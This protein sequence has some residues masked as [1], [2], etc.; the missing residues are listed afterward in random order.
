VVENYSPTNC[1]ALIKLLAENGT[2]QV[3]T[4]IWERG[5]WL[6]DDLDLSQSPGAKY[7]AATLRNQTYKKFT[8]SILKEMDTDHFRSA[9]IHRQRIG[10]DA[11]HAPRRSTVDGRHRHSCRSLRDSG[12]S[13]HQEWRCS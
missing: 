11:G 3:P 6:I 9:A 13:L 1:A 5:Q 8:E 2:W 10:N 12:F 4:L 7:A